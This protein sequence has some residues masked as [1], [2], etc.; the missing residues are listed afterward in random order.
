MGVFGISGGGSAEN[1][2]G[3]DEGDPGPT[4]WRDIFAE[5]R[6]ATEGDDGMGEAAEIVGDAERD[7][8]EG[9][10]PGDE[11]NDFG[12]DSQ[13]DPWGVEGIK[14]EETTGGGGGT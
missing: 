7:G 4:E 5:P 8:A 13:P 6:P 2:A 10:E 3:K 11:A 14:I 9:A 12:D 1:H